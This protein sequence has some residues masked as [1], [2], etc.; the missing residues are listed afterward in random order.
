MLTMNCEIPQTDARTDDHSDCGSD[1]ENTS[2]V[3][4]YR[5]D[6]N[7][8]FTMPTNGHGIRRNFDTHN[9]DDSSCDGDTELSPT[10]AA[11]RF[12]SE[13]DDATDTSPSQSFPKGMSHLYIHMNLK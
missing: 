6:A 11:K 4:D 3:A 12:K 13:S 2:H 7:I 8:S 5:L 9:S 10:P 1:F